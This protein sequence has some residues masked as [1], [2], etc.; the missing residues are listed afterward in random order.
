MACFSQQDENPITEK[1]QEL[2]LSALDEE[3]NLQDENG[4]AART[5]ASQHTRINNNSDCI[6]RRAF[7]DITSDSA[8]S[9]H[10]SLPIKAAVDD[11]DEEMELFNPGDHENF[12]NR[13][14]SA[15][16]DCDNEDIYGL[17]ENNDN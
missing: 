13:E 12:M 7:T 9:T 6:Q 3:F 5:I 17:D 11:S 15:N 14:L 16:E 1:D 4:N 2:V 10:L 8:M